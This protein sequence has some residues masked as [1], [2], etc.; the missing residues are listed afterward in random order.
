MY[1]AFHKGAIRAAD[2]FCEQAERIWEFEKDNDSYTNMAGA[3]ILSLSLMGHG[4]DHAV[5][6][7][8]TAAARMGTRLG[9]FG[10]NEDIA[11]RIDEDMSEEERSA[12]CYA[13]WGVFNWSV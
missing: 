13:A 1:S 10:V 4:K 12:S 9:L 3:V 7:Y 11:V 5:L 2:K 6:L 8:T